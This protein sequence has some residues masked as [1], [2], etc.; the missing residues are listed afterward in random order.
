M[1]FAPS[2]SWY[3]WIAV[4]AALTF[5]AFG[6]GYVV[7]AL[8]RP[9]NAAMIVVIGCLTFSVFRY[10]TTYSVLRARGACGPCCLVK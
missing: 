3:L 8:T 4:Y 9:T 2:G 6:F 5:T 10:A 7:A 1:L